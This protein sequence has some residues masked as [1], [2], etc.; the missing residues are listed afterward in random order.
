[1]G[2]ARVGRIDGELVINPTVDRMQESTL[3]LVVAGTK[4]GVLM[5]ESEAQETLRGRDAR[6]GYERA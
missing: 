6:G 4:D 1:M 2:A 3:D 5:V